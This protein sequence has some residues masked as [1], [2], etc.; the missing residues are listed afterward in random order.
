ML[1][2]QRSRPVLLLVHGWGMNPLVWE[3]LACHLRKHFEV[4][5]PALPG[6]GGAPSMPGWSVTAL[7]RSWLETWPDAFWVGWSLGAQVALAAAG[8]PSTPVRGAVLL[9]GTPRFVVAPGWPCAMAD[10]VFNSFCERCDAEPDATLQAFLGLQ[11]I[12]SERRAA[13]LRTLRERLAEAPAIT[14]QALQ[15]GL[16]VL[17][18]TDLRHQLGEARCPVLWLSGD[19]DRLTPVEAA[20]WSAERMPHARVET[21]PG[22]GHAP[23]VSHQSEVLAQT[24]EWLLEECA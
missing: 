8:Q 17:Q 22:A 11:V 2:A 1:S 21:L 9:G 3:P 18:T 16:H 15:E 10:D 4:H 19:A 24:S 13:T 14:S 12:G 7:A 5:C 20:Q 23:F 6:H